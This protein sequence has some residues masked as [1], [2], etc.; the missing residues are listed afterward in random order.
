M[1]NCG[2]VELEKGA[3]IS[4]VI[5]GGN[6]RYTRTDQR[7]GV[8][9]VATGRSCQDHCSSGAAVGFTDPILWS[10]CS[11]DAFALGT[12]GIEYDK[13]RVVCP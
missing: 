12:I 9:G 3:N 1:I 8:G 4:R 13:R 11:Q 5:A 2:R 6:Y 7:G 10:K